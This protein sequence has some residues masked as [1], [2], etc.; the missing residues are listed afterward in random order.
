MDSLFELELNTAE[1]GQATQEYGWGRKVEGSYE[2]STA[3]SIEIAIGVRH[4]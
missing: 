2:L 3:A 1:T 4:E